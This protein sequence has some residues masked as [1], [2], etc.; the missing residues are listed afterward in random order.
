MIFMSKYLRTYRNT[1]LNIG[2]FLSLSQP[3]REKILVNSNQILFS[4][5]TDR[6]HTDP[7][8][9]VD[10]YKPNIRNLIVNFTNG[11]LKLATCGL[12]D[13]PIKVVTKQQAVDYVF[14]DYGGAVRQVAK[15]N[16]TGKFFP[17]A[18]DK[19]DVEDLIDKLL[20]GLPAGSSQPDRKKD[21]FEFTYCA[22]R[23]M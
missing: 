23:Q 1:T 13:D 3:D 6:W 2:N 14:D 17:N 20:K 5:T 21:V 19:Q 11:S 7:K 18:P 9:I 4:K 22:A 8:E 16:V 12:F 15:P 10:P